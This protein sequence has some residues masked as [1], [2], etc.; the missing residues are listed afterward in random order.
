VLLLAA[1]GTAVGQEDPDLAKIFVE[2]G[3]QGTIIIRSLDGSTA[4]G[5]NEGRAR[6]RFIP[7]STFKIPNWCVETAG[8]TWLFATNPGNSDS[9]RRLD[10]ATFG[11]HSI[12]LA[13]LNRD[14]RIDMFGANWNTAL[15]PRGAPV[16]IWI[17][18]GRTGK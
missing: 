1:S 3:V 4:F 10:A 17:N 16:E 2:R 14:G 15:D 8:K 18:Q 12:R 7:A 13:D 6:E 5:H 11:S 9:W